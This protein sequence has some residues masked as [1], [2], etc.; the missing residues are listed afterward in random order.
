MRRL[1]LELNEIEQQQT[2]SNYDRA[3]GGIESRPLIAPNV[4]E[5]KVRNPTLAN[6][7]IEYVAH[8]APENQ[9]QCDTGLAVEP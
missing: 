2:A 4:E 7:A 9:G 8:G 3:I 6:H 1:A 5:Q